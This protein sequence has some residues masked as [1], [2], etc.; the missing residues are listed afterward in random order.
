MSHKGH[1]SPRVHDLGIKNKEAKKV[2]QHK[3]KR[4]EENLNAHIPDELFPGIAQAI[5]ND[6]LESMETLDVNAEKMWLTSN[7]QTYS[8]MNDMQLCMVN[9]MP[10]PGPASVAYK[11]T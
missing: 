6:Q 2:F 11:T 4:L 8:P 5:D 9:S 7:G 3:I 1:H 10:S